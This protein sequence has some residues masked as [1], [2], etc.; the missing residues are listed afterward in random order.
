LL[1]R[2]GIICAALLCAAVL[3]SRLL[4]AQ[5][6]TEVDLRKALSAKTGSVALPA[7]VIEISRELVI[8][9]D[10]HDL[11]I[12]GTH[13]TIK[14]AAAF[15]GRALVVFPAGKNVRIRDLALDGNR[16]A[17][18]RMIGLP[19]SGTMF[20]RFMPN[21]GILAEGVTSL[22]IA[23]VKATGIAGFAILV[24]TAHGV[25]IHDVEVTDSGGFNA[26]RRNNAAG[27][28]L[29]EEGTADFE[30]GRCLLGNIRG[31]GITLRSVDRGRIFENEFK[32]LAR[33]AIQA[34][35]A[36]AVT[37]ENNN[38]AQLG[39]P[40]E[41][42]DA[43]GAICLRLGGFSGGAVKHNTCSDVLLGGISIA[44]TRNT[45]SGNHLTGL[46]AAH[47][48]AAG[49]FLEAGARDNTVENNAI[50]GYGMS[51]Q[52]LGAAPEVPPNAN[53]AIRNDCSDEMSVASRLPAIRH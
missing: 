49:I 46:N 34:G 20:S 53:R 14:A 8:P 6:K 42:V 38:A 16:E 37:I 5:Q 44:G 43:P 30:I 4:H 27:G 19:P 45:L 11:D 35:G 51:K 47:R 10:A 15:R 2:M 22:E 39:F 13:T 50:A 18:G 28:I 3:D 17:V 48:D 36:T 29:L 21:N 1:A 31:N 52:C 12:H 7:G 41:E 32:V 23:Q 9:V 26:Q 33:D 25:R 40:L 24:N